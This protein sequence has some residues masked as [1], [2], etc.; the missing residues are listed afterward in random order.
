[1][2]RGDLSFLIR[3]LLVHSLCPFFI[4][5]LAFFSYWI[6]STLVEWCNSCV[7]VNFLRP[8][9]IPSSYACAYKYPFSELG[10]R[11]QWPGMAEAERVGI[12]V[13]SSTETWLMGWSNCTPWQKRRP[14]QKPVTGTEPPLS[15]P[16]QLSSFLPGP[17][18]P[19]LTIHAGVLSAQLPLSKY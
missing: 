13:S 1:M 8:M 19:M 9:T 6:V 2:F 7:L 14:S 10:W 16:H 15:A 18:N 11:W 5:L 12:L 3:E 17:T 4:R